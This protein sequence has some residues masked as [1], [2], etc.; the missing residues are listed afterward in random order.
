M[1]QDVSSPSATSAIVLVR[2]LL[3]ERSIVGSISADDDLRAAGLTSLDMVNLVLSLE[4]EF[5]LQIPEKAITPANFRSI[6]SIDSLLS[7]LR[8]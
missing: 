8:D 4:A 2:R 3:A 6:S 1:S 7:T 5:N